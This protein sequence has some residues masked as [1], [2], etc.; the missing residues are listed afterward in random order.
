M[1]SEAI[2]PIASG[3]EMVTGERILSTFDQRKDHPFGNKPLTQPLRSLVDVSIREFISGSRVISRRLV[4]TFPCM[5]LGVE[6]EAE[7]E[8]FCA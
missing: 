1:I 8:I 7:L 4:K 3:H 5:S 6:L 2:Q